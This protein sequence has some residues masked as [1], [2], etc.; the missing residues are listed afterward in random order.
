VYGLTRRDADAISS[1]S[2]CALSSL[3]RLHPHTHLSRHSPFPPYLGSACLSLFG[4]LSATAYVCLHHSLLQW[5]AH[6][7][8]VTTLP[9]AKEGG[10]WSKGE[11]WVRTAQ[12][13]TRGP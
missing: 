1:A 7:A 3:P 11:H 2:K 5:A 12:P 13:S 6:R 10:A 9:R 8:A 4:C